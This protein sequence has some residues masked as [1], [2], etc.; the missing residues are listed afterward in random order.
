MISHEACIQHM[1]ALGVGYFLLQMSLCET[2]CPHCNPPF[3]L[4]LAWAW[5]CFTSLSHVCSD[6][7]APCELPGPEGGGA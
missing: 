4:S 5:A 7:I 3:F 6:G 2:L 1:E